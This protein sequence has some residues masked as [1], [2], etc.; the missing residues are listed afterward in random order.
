[1]RRDL[2]KLS[3]QLSK[4]L[5]HQPERWGLSLE[6]GGWVRI[7]DLVAAARAHN[8][9]LD[10]SRLEE[11]IRQQ[12]KPRFAISP[13]GI[14]VR[15]SYGHSV[16]ID[17]EL[18]PVEP[19]EKLY[20]GTARHSVDAILHEGLHPAGRRFVH[21]SEDRATAI[22]VGARHG[23]PA[24]LEIEALVLWRQG[25]A[26]YAPAAGIWLTAKVPAYGLWLMRNVVS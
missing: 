17:L 22:Q 11:L 24:V 23:S 6:P 13:D 26:F 14:R 16:E 8:V 25:Q 20:H 9:E 3:K 12:P 19:P 10:R 2:I 5:R 4:V 18:E 15:A 21:L 7:D 1:M